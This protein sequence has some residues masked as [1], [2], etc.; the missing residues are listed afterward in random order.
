[1]PAAV[2]W[3][4]FQ[5]DLASGWFL[6]L[7]LWYEQDTSLSACG[8]SLVGEPSQKELLSEEAHSVAL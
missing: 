4:C 1:V 6:S 5:A 2:D 7:S 8:M 3:T